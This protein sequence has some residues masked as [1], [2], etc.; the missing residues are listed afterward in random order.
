MS[1]PLFKSN[2]LAP[3]WMWSDTY[4]PEPGRVDR[5]HQYILKQDIVTSGKLTD[6]P[7]LFDGDSC[8]SVRL[9]N[10]AR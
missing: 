8:F 3:P 9:V 4:C 5:Y 1:Q 2:P 6:Q 10:A 7:F